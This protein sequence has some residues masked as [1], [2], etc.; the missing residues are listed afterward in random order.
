MWSR[1]HGWV[2]GQSDPTV[3]LNGVP[4]VPYGRLREPACTEPVG[5]CVAPGPGGRMEPARAEGGVRTL[6]VGFRSALCRCSP[7]CGA[8]TAP[9]PPGLRVWTRCGR[10]AQDQVELTWLASCLSRSGCV[11][12]ATVSG[13]DRTRSSPLLPSVPEVSAGRSPERLRDVAKVTQ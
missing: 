7:L 10:P 13:G 4:S 6:C 11:S 5:T 9:V 12:S 3:T 8:R 1:R 2:G